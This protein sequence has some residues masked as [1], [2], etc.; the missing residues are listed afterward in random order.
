MDT[1]MYDMETNVA[2]K[3]RNYLDIISDPAMLKILRVF[4]E[5]PKAY[6]GRQM[7]L[8]AGLSHR[9]ASKYLDLLEGYSMVAK[10]TAGKAYLYS[11]S[12]NYFTNDVIRPLILK[13][14]QLYK[15]T[16]Q[17]IAQTFRPYAK[18]LIIYGSYALH[19]ETVESD[20]DL[21]IVVDKKDSVLEAAIDGYVKRMSATYALEVSPHVLTVRELKEKIETMVIKAIIN[22]GDW[23]TGNKRELQL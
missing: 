16:K 22:D 17:D 1:I 3:I 21:C 2:M 15:K 9:T 12:E 4:I 20:L 10:K 7:A 13:E 6:T 14:Q 18:A 23:I 19:Q 8:L 5:Y 11:L